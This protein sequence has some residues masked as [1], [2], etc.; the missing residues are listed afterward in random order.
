MLTENKAGSGGRSNFDAA[1]AAWAAPLMLEPADGLF[2][3]ELSG[4]PKTIE[5]VA[6]ALE[7]CGTTR[8]EV[9]AAIDRLTDLHMIEPV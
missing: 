1:R 7:S 8:R 9:K 6:D 2:F 5:E 3:G 4:G